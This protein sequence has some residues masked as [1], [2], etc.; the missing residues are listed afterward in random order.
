MR[1]L[2]IDRDRQNAQTLADTLEEK[3][4]EPEVFTT[5]KQGLAAMET[6]YH[7]VVFLDPA[8]EPT[9][10]PI[11]LA[12]R[13]IRPKY[14]PF[15]VLTGR[16]INDESA[17][18]SGLNRA[19]NK[20]FGDL[21]DLDNILH[22]AENLTNIMNDLEVDNTS[23]TLTPPI[24]PKPLYKDLMFNAMDRADRYG[25]RSALIDFTIDSSEGSGEGSGE[26][27]GEGSGAPVDQDVLERLKKKMLESRRQSD[28]I[29]ETG[30]NRY[31]F[32]VLRPAKLSEAV[33]GARRYFD[34]IRHEEAINP[35]GSGNLHLTIS[36][37]EL[38]TGECSFHQT[39]NT[40]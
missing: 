26:D 5:K 6:E 18:K 12:M 40:F 1:C 30:S 28:I 7:E 23:G 32:L 19:L 4:H 24:M 9:A 15:I 33:D 31:S 3:G 34:M 35:A 27:S 38:P 13:R 25:E 16:D 37:T 39:L 21:S 20:P 8:P 14:Y 36:V 10:R 11:V 2:I 17:L 22:C 29:C